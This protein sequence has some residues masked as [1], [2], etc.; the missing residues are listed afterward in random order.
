MSWSPILS[1][2]AETDSEG[3]PF[4]CEDGGSADFWNYVATAPH[5]VRILGDPKDVPMT[6]D[7]AMSFKIKSTGEFGGAAREIVAIVT[8]LNKTATKMK[9][10]LDQQKR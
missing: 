9:S 8:D 7:S 4:K 5:S 1:N 6:C 2:A 3:G 10:L